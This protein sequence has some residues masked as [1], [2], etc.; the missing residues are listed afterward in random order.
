MRDYKKYEVW[1]KSHELTLYVYKEIIPLFPV[2]EQF[3][4]ASQIK[5]AAYSIPLN[6]A[7][8]CG[9]NSDKDFV[10]FLDIGLGS[11]HEL[12]YCALLVHDLN[13]IALEKYTTLNE[14]TNEVKAKLI[15]LIK[16]IRSEH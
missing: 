5:R 7:E 10:H 16:S 9:R 6:I 4:L 11:T 1:T 13:I 3:A 14:K 15:E 2:S 12:E 8:G